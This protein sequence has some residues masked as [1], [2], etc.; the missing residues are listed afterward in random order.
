MEWRLPLSWRIDLP[1]VPWKVL[2]IGYAARELVVDVS[3]LLI[4]FSP[5][6]NLKWV[7]RLKIFLLLI[8]TRML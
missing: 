5:S 2:Y 7:I 6:E 4:K 3:L 1:T 8:H